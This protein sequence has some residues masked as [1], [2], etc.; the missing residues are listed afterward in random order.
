MKFLLYISLFIVV[1]GNSQLGYTQSLQ[2]S[3]INAFG[4][5][6][7]HQGVSLSQSLGQ[8]SIVGNSIQQETIVKQGFQQSYLLKECTK[9]KPKHELTIY[10][11]PTNGTIQ[12]HTTIEKNTEVTYKI[13]NS[14]GAICQK[15]SFTIHTGNKLQLDQQLAEGTYILLIT[16]RKNIIHEHLILKK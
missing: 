7:K 4:S 3:S 11:N 15:G 10:P 1:L 8:S 13:I 16:F 5:V 6:I 9:N 14:L 12:F 2:R